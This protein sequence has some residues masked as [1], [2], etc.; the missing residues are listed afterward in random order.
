LWRI[1]FGPATHLRH[2]IHILNA[3]VDHLS[4]CVFYIFTEFNTVLFNRF[5]IAEKT[6]VH[7]RTLI[8]DVRYKTIGEGIAV[9]LDVILCQFK[10]FNVV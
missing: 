2:P 8:I 7:N 3:F 9:D 4:G 1:L 10:T 6:Q 5:D